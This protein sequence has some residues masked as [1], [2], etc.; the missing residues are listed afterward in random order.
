VEGSLPEKHRLNV[1]PKTLIVDGRRFG[2]LFWIS[3]N[4]SAIL[5]KFKTLIPSCVTLRHI[6]HPGYRGRVNT[7]RRLRDQYKTLKCLSQNYNA[8]A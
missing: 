4:H 5:V 1:V 6:C 7:A 3:I 8:I 2:R